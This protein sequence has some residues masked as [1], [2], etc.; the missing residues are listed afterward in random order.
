MHVRS[1]FSVFPTLDSRLA[2]LMGT[3]AVDADA[4][5]DELCMLCLSSL[6]SQR[7]IWLHDQCGI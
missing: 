3:N 2:A 7:L 6:L 4:S 5:A 1:N